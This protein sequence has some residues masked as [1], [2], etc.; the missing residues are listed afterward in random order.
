MR[1]VLHPEID[2]Q[3]F[4][5]RKMKAFLETG[6]YLEVPGIPH[7]PIDVAQKYVHS[8]L[9]IDLI[10]VFDN[11]IKYFAK[12]HH[13]KPVKG[14]STFEQ[15]IGIDEIK[16]PQHFKWYKELRNKSAHEFAR[17]EWHFLNQ[18][19]EH[20]ANQFEYWQII[21]AQ[22]NFR[23]YLEKKDN[24]KSYVGS[25]VDDFVILAY[26]V[27]ENLV[28]SGTSSSAALYANIPFSD[29]LK[30][31]RNWTRRIIYSRAS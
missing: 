10:S 6:V 9:L 20:I 7:P 2:A 16:S 21:S 1:E 14:K 28:P 8:Q 30:V 25:R 29:F 3:F 11:A 4:E 18:A 5:F 26:E 12:K 13:L 23:K 19:T 31:E 22:L 24:G 27:V 15:L 17:H